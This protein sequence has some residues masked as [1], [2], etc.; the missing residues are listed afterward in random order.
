MKIVDLA[1]FL[2]HYYVKLWSRTTIPFQ[3]PIEDLNLYKMLLT[4]I[5]EHKSEGFRQLS[6]A[7]V[8][9]FEN[10]FWY[11]TERLVVLSLFS[12]TSVQQKQSIARAMKRY[13]KKFS[14][15]SAVQQMPLITPYIHLKDLIGPESWLLFKLTNKQP[16][17]LSKPAS[18]LEKDK[19]YIRIKLQLLHLKAVND[20]SERALELV[21]GYH[22][23]VVTKSQTQ[24]QFLYQVVKHLCEKQNSLLLKPNAECC[25]KKIMS[26]MW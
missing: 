26:E 25:T 22:Q 6:Q 23:S 15:K 4:N 3:A 24:K 8:G 14:F 16:V 12:D 20:S 1:K 7:V 18:L 2:C 19:N 9:K 13:D 11:L 5:K 10:H 17:F 21:T